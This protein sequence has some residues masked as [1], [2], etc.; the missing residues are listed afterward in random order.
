[1]AELAGAESKFRRVAVGRTCRRDSINTLI[2]IDT[3]AGTIE[4]GKRVLK[5]ARF[6]KLGMG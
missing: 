4:K 2:A 1:M 3:P 5:C 6:D